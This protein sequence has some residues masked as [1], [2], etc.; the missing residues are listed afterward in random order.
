V[1]PKGL[2]V[3]S[4]MPLLAAMCF[5][6]GSANALEPATTG[7]LLD[8][9]RGAVVSNASP[10]TISAAENMIGGSSGVEPG[11]LLFGDGAPLGTV[12]FV[13]WDLPSAVTMAGFNLRAL[14]DGTN[15]PVF[16]ERSFDH[17]RLLADSGAG[18]QA[19]YE[20]DV[21]VPY[22]GTPEQDLLVISSAITPVTAS[23]FRAEFTQALT[24]QFCGP[25]VVELD[26]FPAAS[27]ADGDY[28]GTTSAIDALVALKTAVDLSGCPRCACDVDDSGDVTATDALAILSSAVGLSIPLNCPACFD[29]VAAAK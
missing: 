20:S 11:N 1:S 29:D 18:F 4:S 28:S 25:R 7:D 27:C 19:Y 9:S 26:G 15:T 13:E 23:R 24:C 17:V 5:L 21:D 8:V 3:A 16:Y 22:N 12:M 14:D 6:D 2:M 10:N